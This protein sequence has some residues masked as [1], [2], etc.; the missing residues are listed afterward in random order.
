MSLRGEAIFSACGHYRFWLTRQGMCEIG[1]LFK[2]ETPALV[3][4][5]INPSVAGAIT[6]QRD[7]PDPTTT[8]E[9]GFAHRWGCD[10][11]IKV[12]LRAFVATQPQ[13]MV[14]AARDGVDV[15]G[16]DMEVVSSSGV[17][18]GWFPTAIAERLQT[19]RFS[20][21]LALESAFALAKRQGGIVLAGWGGNGAKEDVGAVVDLAREVGVDLMC[22]AVNDDGSPTHPLY[23][24]YESPLKKWHPSGW[25]PKGPKKK[26]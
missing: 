25:R 18:L 9:C 24:P 6:E 19:G 17:E 21:R 1:P 22:L 10:L 20:N 4:I 2:T 15:V 16:L 12:N 23:L 3:S 11:L 14:R 5:G 26:R 8:K 7:K 13:T